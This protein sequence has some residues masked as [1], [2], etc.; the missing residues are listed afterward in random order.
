MDSILNPLDREL[1]INRDIRAP[2]EAV[3]AAWTDPKR[4]AAWWCPSDCTLVSCE[5][6]VRPG[7]N[8]H[9]TMRVPSGNVIAKYGVYREVTPPARLVFTYATDYGNGTVDPET[10]VSI[11]LADLGG[12]RTRLTLWHTGFDSADVCDDH[13]GGWNRAM[14][15]LVAACEQT[16]P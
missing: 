15:P 9:R 1:V 4:A 7:G 6:D 12:G 14:N 10:I 2:R 11:G 16:F 5:M 8:W 13:R 3:F